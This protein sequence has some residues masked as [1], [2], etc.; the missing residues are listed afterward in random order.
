[1]VPPEPTGHKGPAQLTRGCS[2]S[3]CDAP[4]PA[5]TFWK[6]LEPSRLAVREPGL[7]Q[8]A[9]GLLGAGPP[10]AGAAPGMLRAAPGSLARWKLLRPV[11]GLGWRGTFQR[12][13]LLHKML[14]LGAVL[15]ASVL[16]L[17][18]TDA[19]ARAGDTE[20]SVRRWTYNMKCYDCVVINTFQCPTLRT[21]PYETR[22]CL[23]LSIRV[24]PRELLVYKNCTDNCSFVY[25]AHQP[26]PAPKSSM[27]TNS[28]Y[29]VLCCNKMTCNDGGPTNVERD[30]LPDEPLEELI[31][32]A[33]CLR[34]S[35]L[36]L[37]LASILLS[38]A[39]SWVVGAPVL[40]P[41][42]PRAVRSPLMS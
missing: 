36:L 15:L 24:N 9:R 40:S 4:T 3:P 20:L 22:R 8:R 23:T 18:D 26:P 35:G 14:L 32:G 19:T 11:G 38:G 30:I 41:P 31:E 39:L 29:W 5:G 25:A 17:V 27:K 28:F 2:P 16:T 6:L 13:R 1:M 42:L 7:G 10:G 34:G 37:G 21:C 33:V 12:L